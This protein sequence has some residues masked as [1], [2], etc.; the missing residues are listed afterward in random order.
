MKSLGLI[1]V[2]SVAAAVDALDLMC[3]AADVEFVTWE[4]KLGG[5]LVTVIVEGQISAEEIEAPV[6]PIP[7]AAPAASAKAI[8]AY[9]TIT[10]PKI[11]T[12]PDR[13]KTDKADFSEILDSMNRSDGFASDEE[14]LNADGLPISHKTQ[15]VMNALFAS[16][17]ASPFLRINLDDDDD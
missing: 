6:Q 11:E 8:S 17:K 9:R 16:P 2:E 13:S 7:A 14:E 4:R 15:H 5:R 1:E 3:K 12:Q 10:L